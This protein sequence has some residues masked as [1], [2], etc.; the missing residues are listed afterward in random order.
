MMLGLYLK[1]A[2]IL[3]GHIKNV[4]KNDIFTVLRE[5]FNQDLMKA[6]LGTYLF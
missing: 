6:Y 5:L 1:F 4:Y 2:D 3:Q